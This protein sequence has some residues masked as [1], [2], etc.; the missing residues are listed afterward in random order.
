MPVTTGADTIRGGSFDMAVITF[1]TYDC[2]VIFTA[3]VV[4]WDLDG[5][6]AKL[7]SA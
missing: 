4:V 2:T 3:T 6:V 5:V 7:V 1:T